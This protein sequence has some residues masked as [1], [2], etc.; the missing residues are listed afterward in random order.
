MR[1]W[2]NKRRPDD[3]A[4]QVFHSSFISGRDAVATEDVEARMSPCGEHPDHHFR[5]LSLGKKHP[6]HLVPEDGLQLFQLQGWGDAE[7]A[8]VT[9]ETAV[10]HQDVAVGIEEPTSRIP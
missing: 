5:Y 3:I 9:I 10:R 6:E 4:R 7:H 2:E 8:A 1:S